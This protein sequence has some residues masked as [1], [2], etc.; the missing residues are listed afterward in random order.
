MS[1]QVPELKEDFQIMYVI[2]NIRKCK[3]IMDSNKSNDL[4]D[5]ELEI[6]TQL[7][8]FYQSHPFL[9]KRLVKGGDMSYLFTMLRNLQQVQEGNKT[10]TSV[11]TKLGDELA[12][13]FIPEKYLNK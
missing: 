2:D 5:I 13:K 3:E 11:E 10:L 4:F 1:E 9:V 6:M 8:D 12:K 7:P